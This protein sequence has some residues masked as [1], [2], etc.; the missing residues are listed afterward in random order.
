MIH[1]V[2]QVIL[3]SPLPKTNGNFIAVLINLALGI[4]GGISFIIVVWAGM[5][6][7]L[8]QGDPSKTAEARNQIL[9]AAIGI[10]VA[11]GA[12]GFVAFIRSI[13]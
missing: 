12:G 5:K 9:Y 6:Y 10:A 11:V 7:V 1:L 4:L 8:S 13:L 3:K 2:A